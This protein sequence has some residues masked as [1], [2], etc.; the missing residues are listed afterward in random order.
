MNYIIENIKNYNDPE[1]VCR[2]LEKLV[3]FSCNID[4]Y[5]NVL[6]LPND[7]RILEL[8]C[9]YDINGKYEIMY[10]IINKK[11]VPNQKCFK[12][13]MKYGKEYITNKKNYDECN[14]FLNEMVQLLVEGGYELTEDDVC[15]ASK[16]FIVLENCYNIEINDKIKSCYSKL[17]IELFGIKKCINLIKKIIS[18]YDV[19]PNQQCLMKSTISNNKVGKK[20]IS[21]FYP[22][23][24]SS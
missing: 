13:L 8:V 17:M 4:K 23:V 19:H 22:N 24:F 10:R 7:I 12:N 18:V 1:M 14:S 21:C 5:V 9:L 20:F 16:S 6:E 2:L 11:I 15:L 3:T